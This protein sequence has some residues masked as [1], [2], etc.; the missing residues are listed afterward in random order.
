[1]WVNATTTTAR[2]LSRSAT[3]QLWRRAVTLRQLSMRQLRDLHAAERRSSL[4][5][6]LHVGRG[7]RFL[8][9][10]G[11]TA[12]QHGLRP[13][14]AEAVCVR[15]EQPVTVPRVRGDERRGTADGELHRCTGNPLLRDPAHAT[16]T[17]ASDATT[18]QH[19]RR[20]VLLRR[21]R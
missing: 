7:G 2:W 20:L 11:A 10:G 18:Q 8:L 12:A 21:G 6:W 13:V 1:M 17:C 15:E 5:G 4:K 16:T 9:E 19:V 3:S 14:S